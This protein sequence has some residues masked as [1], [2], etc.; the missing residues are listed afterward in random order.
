MIIDSL[1]ALADRDALVALSQVTH[2]GPVRLGRLRDHFG[3]LAFAWNASEPELRLVLDERTCRSVITARQRI[4]PEEVM[5]RIAGSGAEVAT[6]L[7]DNYPR[8]LR[9]IPG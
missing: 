8:I 2:I 5:Q 4:S 3:S 7:D 9:E 1:D 6:V